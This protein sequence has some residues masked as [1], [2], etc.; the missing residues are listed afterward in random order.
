MAKGILSDDERKMA[1]DYVAFHSWRG[2]GAI[3]TRLLEKGKKEN[4]LLCIK[5]IR[6]MAEMKDDVAEKEEIKE[7]TIKLIT[8]LGVDD[9]IHKMIYE[10]NSLF[11]VK[12]TNDGLIVE[13]SETLNSTL[14]GLGIE[15]EE[16]RRIIK[17]VI[18]GKVSEQ[19]KYM[20]KL[21]TMKIIVK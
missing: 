3:K 18:F 9:I 11:T 19:R 2:F 1:N 15:D 17:I 20:L 21:D 12:K 14:R 7:K 10:P 16:E 6:L 13:S 8:G 4:V 5:D